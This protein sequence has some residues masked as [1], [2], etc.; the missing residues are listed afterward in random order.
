MKPLKESLLGDMEDNLAVGD[1]CAVI[2][3][4]TKCIKRIDRDCY[5]SIEDNKRLR[6]ICR[7]NFKRAKTFNSIKDKCIIKFVNDD[8]NVKHFTVFDF[9]TNRTK[10]MV[11]HELTFLASMYNKSVNADDDVI[12]SKPFESNEPAKNHF[13]TSSAK[14]KQLYEIYIID[15]SIAEI[16]FN[17]HK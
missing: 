14:F 9:T 2:Y 11:T 6:Q 4:W 16:F 7:E 5:T 17:L 15:K 10:M 12:L 1:K 8:K 13:Y 3:D